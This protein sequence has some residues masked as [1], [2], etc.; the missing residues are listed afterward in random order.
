MLNSFWR[1]KLKQLD[2]CDN[3]SKESLEIRQRNKE[4]NWYDNNMKCYLADAIFASNKLMKEVDSSP[5]V[6]LVDSFKGIWTSSI[7]NFWVF[8]YQIKIKDPA[9]KI[10]FKYTYSFPYGSTK[11]EIFKIMLIPTGINKT[12]EVY[13]KTKLDRSCRNMLT[14]AK[15][16]SWKVYPLYYQMPYK[17][18]DRY[19]CIGTIDFNN[20]TQADLMF[21]YRQYRRDINAHT[22]EEVLKTVKSEI[23]SK[24]DDL[25]K[26]CSKS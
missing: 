10:Q 1:E 4:F 25:I 15:N 3:Y 12:Y 16:D 19:K 6:E 5:I 11:T 20:A 26:D 23:I 17:E 2:P 7:E 24:I 9:E 18:N 14:F 22:K 21:G 8:T 13:Y